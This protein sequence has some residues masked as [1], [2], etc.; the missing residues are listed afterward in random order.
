MIFSNTKREIYYILSQLLINYDILLIHKIYDEKKKLEYNISKNW[1][2]NNGFKLNKFIYENNNIKQKLFFPF[3]QAYEN[4]NLIHIKIFHV[5]ILIEVLSLNGFILN[6]Y[7][8]HYTDPTLKE[9]CD[10]INYFIKKY[11]IYEINK[12]KFDYKSYHLTDLIGNKC[13]RSI[14]RNIINDNIIYEYKTIAIHNNGFIEPVD[15]YP[16]ILN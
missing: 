11:S 14:I 12:K 15:R 3:N 8:N 6:Y 1:H 7:N 4:L 10:T 16:S 13:I 5:K 9:K 2:I